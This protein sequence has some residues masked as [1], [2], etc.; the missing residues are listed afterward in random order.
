MTDDELIDY[1]I[2]N[3]PIKTYNRMREIGISR[4]IALGRIK[5][6]SDNETFSSKAKVF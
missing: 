4:T 1:F 3:G 2:N 5:S 6:I